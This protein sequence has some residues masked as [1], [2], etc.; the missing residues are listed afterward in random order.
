MAGTQS[1]YEWQFKQRLTSGGLNLQTA[2]LARNT[3]ELARLLTGTDNEVINQSGIFKGF[4]ASV[5]VGTLKVSVG[6]GLGQLFDATVP[7]PD[8]KAKWMEL[9]AAV[10]VTLA[11]GDATNP[12]WDVIEAQPAIVDGPAEVIDF[13]DPANNT[14][15]PAVVSLQKIATAALQVRA[16]TPGANPKLLAGVAGW[17]P[18]AYQYVEANAL[19][20]NVNRTMY[21]RPILRTRELSTP[22]SVTGV[23]SSFSENKN[24]SGGGWRIEADGAAGFLEMTLDGTFPENGQPFHI[25]A[26]SAVSISATGNYV[27]G[28]LPL[29]SARIH[30]YVA[31]P[32][33]PA[34]YAVSMAP[35]E[36]YIVD[37]TTP[38]VGTT[39]SAGAKGCIVVI[40]GGGPE[41]ES[42]MGQRGGP[43]S[44]H[45]FTDN[46]WGSFDVKRSQMLYI[47]AAYY[48]IAVPGIISQFVSGAWVAVKRKTGDTFDADLPIA[49]PITYNLWSGFAGLPMAL[50]TTATRVSLAV[51]ATLAAAASLHIELEDNWTGVGGVVGKGAPLFDLRNNAVGAEVVGGHIELVTDDDGN[52][53]ISEAVGV[54]AVSTCA[55][56]VRAYQD[57]ILAMR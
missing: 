50:P 20:L 38:N 7:E 6:P 35:R 31:P 57:K 27:G 29:A 37:T 44:V 54:G 39:V 32:P 8:S 40:G 55:L 17:V 19:A 42:P 21:C 4:V 13:F 28:G 25:P 52:I 24:I 51:N 45:S 14:F 22:D 33:Y 18:I 49:G 56:V 10:E 30:A 5:V 36:L 23:T 47:G 46:F 41:H 16:G 12:R 48:D 53:K 15:S 9:R 11:V 3:S 26:G 2:Y 43:N 34:G 1:R